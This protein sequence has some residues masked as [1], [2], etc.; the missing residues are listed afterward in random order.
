[1]GHFRKFSKTRIPKKSGK[2]TCLAIQKAFKNMH[3]FQRRSLDCTEI[4]TICH[5]N[6]PNTIT[7]YILVADSYSWCCSL[8][9]SY[10]I[11]RKVTQINPFHQAL[12]SFLPIKVCKSEIYAN[13]IVQPWDMHYTYFFWNNLSL[14]VLVVTKILPRFF[15]EF[16]NLTATHEIKL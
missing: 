1:M 2:V 4:K 16:Q 14:D 8:I 5:S 7:I 6:N 12:F 9:H 11:F 10:D 15:K 13:H 3:V